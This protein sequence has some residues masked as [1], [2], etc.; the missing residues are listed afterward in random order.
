MFSGSPYGFQLPG[1]NAA[2][3]RPQEIV[4]PIWDTLQ[5]LVESGNADS[6]AKP[7]RNENIDSA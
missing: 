5:G 1:R 7:K 6:T 4:N 3:T 2:K